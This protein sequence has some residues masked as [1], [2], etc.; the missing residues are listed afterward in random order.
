MERYLD[1][2]RED[3]PPRGGRHEGAGDGQPL[4]AA[5]RAVAGRARGR[6]AV[7]H[8]RRPRGA[9]RLPR[10]RRV[11]D[12][13][14]SSPAPP[15]EPHQLEIT[16]DGERVQIVDGRRQRRGREAR[17]RPQPRTGEAEPDRAARVPHPGQSRARGSSAS[18][19][20]SATKCATRRRCGRACAAAAREPALS[21]VTISGPYG[22]NGARRFAEPAAHLRLPPRRRRRRRAR[23]G[24]CSTLARRAYRRPVTD[25]DVQDLLPF[26]GSGR[27]RRRLRPGHPAG[28]RTRCSSARSSCSASS[29]SRPALA[30]G[31][32]F[33]VSDLELASRLSFFLWSSIPDDELLERRR[34]GTAAAARPCSSGRCGA[35]C[36]DPRSAVAGHQLRR[37]VAVPA[38][39]RGQA[40][41]RPALPRLRRDAAR[42][43]ARARPSCS[44][45]A[46]CARTAASLDLLTA[47][48]TF[49]NERLAKH[50]GIPNVQA[51]T[52]GA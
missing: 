33:R 46:S 13:G 38:R 19:S 3:Q 51:A 40:A 6:A 27:A 35:C 23:R 25:A 49:L 9:E 12:Q 29:A 10:R 1:A 41:R 14:R 48:Y 8:A 15:A 24:S 5:S 50:Y 42:G 7:G 36:A 11:P 47:N 20:S 52:S 26:Y 2:A 4:P 31:T 32:A 18:R 28:A 22:A 34:A 44:S 30:P 21:L 43:H 16:V 17:A 37:A 39:H 45:T